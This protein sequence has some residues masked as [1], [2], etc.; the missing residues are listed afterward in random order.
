MMAPY[1]RIRS[2]SLRRGV[3]RRVF[4]M[5]AAAAVV[6]ACFIEIQPASSQTGGFIAFPPRPG[7]KKGGQSAVRLPAP[8]AQ[9]D[10]QMLVRAV[11]INYDYS[12]ERVSAVGNVQ[13]YF[14]GTT[15]EADRVI[16]DQKTK[17]V[18]A[19]GNVR[20]SEPDGRITY[21]EIMNL[22]DG[23]RDGFV[24]S[25]RLDTPEQTRMA[26]SR[27]DRSSGN[28][29]VFQAGVYTACE[30]CADDPRKPP[31][32]QVKSARIIHDQGEKMMYF[33]SAQL[34]FF[35]VP[36]AYFPF[37]S[38]PDPTAKRKSGVLTP[39]VSFNTKYGA[40]VTI[41]YYWALAP[42]YDVTFSPMITTRQGPLLQGEWRH[43]LLNG[44][45]TVRASG[46][47][48][49]DKAAFG[50]DSDGDR[51][52]R[53]D[54]NSSGQFR[55]TEKWVWGWDGTLLTDKSYYRD[56]GFH[57]VSAADLLA[58]TPDYVAS[59][60]YV[61][62]RGDRSFFDVRA[63]HYYGLM[64]ADIQQNLPV[65]HPI[66][67]H[68]YTFA[69]PVL[70]GEVKLRSNLTSLSREGTNFEP[71]TLLAA[72]GALCAP[73]TADPAVKI[74]ANCLLRGVPGTYTRAST[75]AS[76]RRAIVDPYGQVFTPFAS[77]RADLA[78]AD[79]KAQPGVANFMTPGETEVA[80]IMPTV[81]VEYRYPF[82]N[83]QS[84]GTQ[85][86]EP[87]A[88]VVIRPNEEKIGVLPNE[89]SQ[90]FLF[91]A[92]NLFRDNKFV[93][94]DRVEGGGRLN[95]GLQYTA[96]FNRGGFVNVVFGQSFHLF[97][98][99]SFAVGGPTNTG[100]GSG[101]DK[102]RSDYVL[103]ATYQPNTQLSLTSRFRLDENDFTLQ[104]SEY[105]ATV[106]YGRWM[107]TVMYGNYAAQPELGFLESRHGIYGNASFKVTANWMTFGGAR[108]NLQA[109]QLDQ[110]Q[111]GVG[112]ID[113][114]LILALNYVT[115]YSYGTTRK[116]D[117][118]V[119]MQ[120]S[121]RTLGG[122][123]TQQNLS[124]LGTR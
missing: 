32:W 47:F 77:V 111:I 36:I 66:V 51:E 87:I 45:Y 109:N 84:W 41:P 46:I 26:A 73:A 72:N 2:V 15:L 106:N 85:T 83:V 101:L 33:E 4:G 62:G 19:E 40:A 95:A 119:L 14:A 60:V 79:I 108:Y 114:C 102:A 9:T 112:Y 58:S 63:I 92:N 5:A 37:L 74:P 81:G 1:R 27:A 49:L 16:Y 100:I 89:D 91:D 48:Q 97:G 116:Y 44:T 78:T 24:D 99:N 120:V 29:T 121:L 59:Q 42:N 22:S 118:T 7:E 38:A 10:E 13:I 25:L 39:L 122:Q 94:W 80:R 96:Q 107:T 31:K 23:F 86:I 90:S 104:R 20:L 82:L 67:T 64:P 98:Q 70:G 69:Q 12:N 18:H 57:K 115:T 55:I 110:T 65:I 123:V 103:R 88:Q 50:K 76:W 28:I 113:D 17:R 105:E 75:E 34:E 52:F 53:G 6:I 68:D 71:V 21:G 8:G 93:G 124:A 117:H 61:Q 43:R 3:W 54:I 30:A 35:G 11:E 56:Y